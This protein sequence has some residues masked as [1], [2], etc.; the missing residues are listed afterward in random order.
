MA[1]TRSFLST[2]LLLLSTTTV[3]VEGGFFKKKHRRQKAGTK[4]QDHDAVHV[5]VNKVGWVAH[6]YKVM[7][8]I[9]KYSFDDA[10]IYIAW[11][12]FGWGGGDN[13]LAMGGSDIYVDG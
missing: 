4:Y 11:S 13:D 9:C 2:L 12:F 6:T 8:Y 10:L 7:M 5:V 1:P 3:I